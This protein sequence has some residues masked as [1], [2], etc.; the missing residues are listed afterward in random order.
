MENNQQPREDSFDFNEWSSLARTDPEGFARRRLSRI[1]WVI[2]RAPE[3]SRDRLNG[4][5]FRIDAECRL[6]RTP[7]KACLRLSSMTWDS[8]F[9][10]KEALASFSE[11]ATPHV[12]QSAGGRRPVQTGAPSEE[13][14]GNRLSAR[15]IP[16]RQP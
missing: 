10:L 9:D 3:R 2:E 11:H 12:L 8:F 5:Q 13:A 16:F 14:D 15:I 1:Q 6:A 7:L 4:L